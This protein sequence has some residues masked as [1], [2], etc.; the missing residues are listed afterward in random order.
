LMRRLLVAI[1]NGSISLGGSALG[2]WCG[3]LVR[4]RWLYFPFVSEALS[5]L[6]FA[7]GW[8]LRRAVYARILPRIGRTAVLHYGVVLEDPRTEIGEDV[9]VG[10]GAYLD[11]AVVGDH[12]LI[13]PRSVLLAGGRHHRADRLDIPIKLQGNPPKE[14]LLIGEGAWIGA[15]ATVMAP[16]GHDAI[17][18]AG[19]VVTRE[20]PAYAVVA[21]NPARILRMRD[22]SARRFVGSPGRD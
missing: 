3:L 17:V 16:V 12:V 1:W 7:V 21:G 11:F 6:P 4:R 14:P 2:C 19:S 20:V 8:K 9:W 10:A 13:G 18:G 5:A 15:N 22:G